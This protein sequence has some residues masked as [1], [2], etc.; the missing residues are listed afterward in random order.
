MWN[1]LVMTLSVY[2]GL[3]FLRNC[4]LIMKYKKKI[5]FASRLLEIFKVHKR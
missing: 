3:V 5:I 2:Y 4:F 1:S